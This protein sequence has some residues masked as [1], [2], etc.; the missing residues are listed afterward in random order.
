MKVL[1]RLHKSYTNIFTISIMKGIS[2]VW[3]C[4]NYLPNLF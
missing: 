4:A 3:V 2:N 1:T